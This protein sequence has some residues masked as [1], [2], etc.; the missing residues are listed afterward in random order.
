M[1]PPVS[2][3]CPPTTEKRNRRLLE[4]GLDESSLERLHAPC[5]L[6]IGSATP[7]EVAISVLAEIIAVR[8]GREGA[9]LRATNGPIHAA[10]SA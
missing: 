2:R 4:A 6:D 10:R 9:P 7:E 8:S 1:L 3:S 5:G